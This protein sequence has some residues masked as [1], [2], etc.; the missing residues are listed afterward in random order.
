MERIVWFCMHAERRVRLL[1]RNITFAMGC[2]LFFFVFFSFCRRRGEL[3]GCRRLN[4]YVLVYYCMYSSSAAAFC[5]GFGN[6]KKKSGTAV[7]LHARTS[8]ECIICL[9]LDA[10]GL[11]KTIKTTAAAVG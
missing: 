2:V 8:Y 1:A 11:A 10:V 4:G 9:L 3:A 7:K 5:C 6:N